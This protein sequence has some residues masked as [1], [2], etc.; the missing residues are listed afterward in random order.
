MEQRVLLRPSE[1]AAALA[2]SRASLYALLQRGEI[3]SIKLGA[4]R[5]IAVADL[6]TYVARLRAE[7]DGNA[8]VA[9][10]PAAASANPSDRGDQTGSEG[11]WRLAP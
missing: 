6:E 1:A 4:S 5:R 11:F 7:C 3:P 8:P 9:P 2:I 10:A